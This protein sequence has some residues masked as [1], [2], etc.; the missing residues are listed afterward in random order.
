MS[1]SHAFARVILAGLTLFV[2]GG[3]AKSGQAQAAAAKSQAAFTKTVNALYR[4]KKAALPAKDLSAESIEDATDQY[5]AV[6]SLKQYLTGAQSAAFIQDSQRLT[7]A[8][9]MYTVQSQIIKAGGDNGVISLSYS[10][11]LLIST[12][13]DLV[14][15]NQAYAK[16]VSK[17]V[18]MI[19]AQAKAR[20]AIQKLYKDKLA[21]KGSKA[22]LQKKLTQKAITTAKKA[23][24]SVKYKP[25]ATVYLPYVT[26]AQDQYDEDHPSAVTSSTDTSDTTSSSSSSSSS[27]SDTT[28][29]STTS[30]SDTTGTTGSSTA[31]NSDYYGGSSSSTDDSGSTYNYNY[32]GDSGASGSST[33]STDSTGSTS[34]TGSSTGTTGSTG[35]AGSTGSTQS[36]SSLDTGDAGSLYGD[37]E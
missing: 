22:A 24:T 34:T 21:K 3:C 35:S 16:T 30:S 18:G 8:R 17:K 19:H 29:N 27:S 32:S 10:P 14:N 13:N 31:D 23:I 11:K 9:Q 7:Q 15:S 5:Q 20:T 28:S 6:R 2:L 33:G 36:S 26:K 25:F 12:Y 37:G 4:D 1:H